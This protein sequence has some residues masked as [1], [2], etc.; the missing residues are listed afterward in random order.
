MIMSEPSN[1]PMAAPESKNMPWVDQ[2]ALGLAILSLLG[3]LGYWGIYKPSL[4]GQTLSAE[5]LRAEA[6]KSSCLRGA[7]Q[8]QLDQNRPI[9]RE[10]VWEFEDDCEKKESI[11]KARQERDAALIEQKS[12]LQK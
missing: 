11:E 6:E 10:N 9:T 5:Q 12:A 7:I 3:A 1:E 2:A 4:A 8:A